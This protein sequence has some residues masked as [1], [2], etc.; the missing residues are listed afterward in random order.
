MSVPFFRKLQK[1]RH[2]AKIVTGPEDFLPFGEFFSPAKE[3]V[4]QKSDGEPIPAT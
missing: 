3:F 2:A 1:F 4:N